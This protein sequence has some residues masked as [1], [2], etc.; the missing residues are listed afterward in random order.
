VDEFKYTDD[1]IVFLAAL[2]PLTFNDRRETSIIGGSWVA[3]LG[4][5]VVPGYENKQLYLEDEAVPPLKTLDFQYLEGNTQWQ[6][7]VLRMQFG[8]LAGI[9]YLFLELVSSCLMTSHHQSSTPTWI[10]IPIWCPQFWRSEVLRK[11][12]LA[13]DVLFPSNLPRSRL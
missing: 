1:K 7:S 4:A 8:I 6:R 5:G 2:F 9:L 11:D 3:Q 12:A 10:P 13:T